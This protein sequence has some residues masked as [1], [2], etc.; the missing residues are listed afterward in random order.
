MKLLLTSA[1][2]DSVIRRARW[3][4]LGGIGLLA[5]TLNAGGKGIFTSVMMITIGAC[6][7]SFRTW[8]ED[9]GL[10]MLSCLFFVLFL[11]IYVGVVLGRLSD[12]V[13]HRDN[14]PVWLAIDV[15]VA[16]ALLWILLRILLTITFW[17]W[18]MSRAGA[19]PNERNRTRQ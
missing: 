17:N 13:R 4:M 6:G 15:S 14:L 16:G 3:W 18:R 1:K 2:V 11:L 10:W 5:I 19:K 8:R 12:F 9:K 7:G